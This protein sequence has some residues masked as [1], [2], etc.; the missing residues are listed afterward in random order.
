MCWKQLSDISKGIVTTAFRWRARLWVTNRFWTLA[1]H[2]QSASK[3]VLDTFYSINKYSAF[4]FSLSKLKFYDC[5]MLM[6]RYVCTATPPSL[7]R[8]VSRKV[9]KNTRYVSLTSKLILHKFPPLNSLK[10][11]F[12]CCFSSLSVESCSTLKKGWN[13]QTTFSVS[14]MKPFADH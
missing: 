6:A 2:D 1:R 7:M 3:T 10:I 13:M 9:F 11:L 8:G 14:L 4:C 5:F 12:F